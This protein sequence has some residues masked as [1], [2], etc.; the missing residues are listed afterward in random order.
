M[1]QMSTY[2]V[3]E[4]THRH[5]EQNGGYQGRGSREEMDLGRDSCH[6]TIYNGHLG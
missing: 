3:Q 4:Q 2:T 1:V 5:R 6:S